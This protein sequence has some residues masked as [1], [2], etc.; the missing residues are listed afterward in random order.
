MIFANK[1][2]FWLLLLLIP[3]VVHY[4]W[5]LKKS[6]ASMNVSSLTAFGDVST[7]WKY[8]MRHVLFAFR[9]IVLALVIV[10]LARPQ[11]TDKWEDR[12]IE[13]VDIVMALDVSGSML[14][15]DFKPNRIDAAKEIG[16]EFIS[17]RPDDRMG[18]VV[19]AGESY[20]QCPLTIDHAVL[21]NLFSEVKSGIIEDGTAIGMG[22]ATAVNRL[23][24]S[25]AVSKVIILLTD[26]V[27]NMGNVSPVAAAEFAQEYDIR[28]YTIGIGKNGMAPYP[29]QTPFGIQ[30]QNV[31]VRIDEDIL[32]QIAE[33]TGGKYFRAT[34]N[35]SLREI[36]SEI[37]SLEKTQ[38][39]V[40]MYSQPKE[41]FGLLLLA[42]MGLLL[43]EIILRLTILKNTF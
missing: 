6:A 15:E 17:S 13:G 34:D 25:K 30:Y 24:D 3:V 14:A 36:Y 26:G 10:V 20:T 12:K 5:R 2:Y 23:K 35:Q 42:A 29:F 19:F 39:E 7:P 40:R 18:L 9:L 22:L 8:Y 28:V 43:I 1:E 33:S 31:E 4:V 27:N 16:M 38:L 11:S 32:Q 41:E 37:D 21:L